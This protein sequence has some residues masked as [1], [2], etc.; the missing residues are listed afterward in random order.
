M[1]LADAR[2]SDPVNRE[3]VSALEGL[4]V[5]YVRSDYHL[6]YKYVFLSHGRVVWTSELGPAQTEWYTPFREEAARA[7]DVALVPRSFRFARRIERRLKARGITYRRAD[8]L[9]PVLYDFSE[10]VPVEE[11]R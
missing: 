4:G 3:F 8:L 7:S 2:E 11:L 1:Y 5:R 10:S 9:Y 6:S